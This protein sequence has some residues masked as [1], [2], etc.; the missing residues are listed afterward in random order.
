MGEII[1]NGKYSFVEGP[2]RAGEAVGLAG[3]P[4]KMGAHAP[5]TAIIRPNATI[6]ES[7]RQ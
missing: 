1:C 4:L 7:R 2:D 6:E 3:R 5:S